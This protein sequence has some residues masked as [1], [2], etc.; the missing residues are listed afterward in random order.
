MHFVRECH[1]V[2]IVLSCVGHDV[3]PVTSVN[4]DHLVKMA[5]ALFSFVGEYC[6]AILWD[7]ENTFFFFFFRIKE[8]MR[9]GIFL[10]L[11]FSLLHGLKN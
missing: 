2:L 6:V 5:C 1:S 8:S 9:L 4:F 7:N 10:F 3:C 11:I